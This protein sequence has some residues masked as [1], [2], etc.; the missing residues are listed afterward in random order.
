M[1]FLDHNIYT[2][3]WIAPLEIE[4]RA[5]LL[6][7]DERHWGQ[8]PIT[9][10]DEYY[11]YA[12]IMCGHHV[13]IATFPA[14]QEYGTGSAAALA[15]H[16]KTAFPNLWFGL[17]VGVAAGLPNLLSDPP[18]DIR[19]GDVLVA[20][21]L[22]DSAGLVAYDLG[23]VVGED[24]V[25]PLRF[26]QRFLPY[27][28]KMKGKLHINGNFLDPGQELDRY[29]DINGDGEEEEIVRPRR[30]D[31]ERT[32]VWYGPL[33]SGEKL[34]RNARQRNEL[35][36]RFNV[37]G[38]EMEAAGTM[39]RIPVGVIR[40]VCDYGDR[41][42]NKEWQ[43]YAAAM[44]AAYGKALTSGTGASSVGAG[45]SSG[46][47]I[48]ACERAHESRP[49]RRY[50]RRKRPPMKPEL[51]SP[52]TI[53]GHSETT[54]DS[55]IHHARR[56]WPKY[57]NERPALVPK[58]LV[59]PD[60]PGYLRPGS[61]TWEIETRKTPWT[62]VMYGL[63]GVG[64]S[65]LCL[66]AVVENENRF[67]GIFY[68]DASNNASALRDFLEIISR[69]CNNDS[70]W[71][72]MKADERIRL[73]R[74][75]LACQKK[76]W[77]LIVD[78]AG[79]EDV[80]LDMF[81]PTGGPGTI[82]ITTTDEQ[83]A[84]HSDAYCRIEAMNGEDAV[85]LLLKYRQPEIA[86][87][88]GQLEAAR[89][90]AADL[91]GGHHLAVT[92]AGSCIFSKHC[93][94]TEYCE[95]FQRSP[96][97]S[98]S[99]YKPRVGRRIGS[100]RQHVWKTFT[101]LLDQ[102]NSSN[103]TGSVQAIELLRTL[104]F[105]HHEGIQE[106]LFEEPWKDQ[107][108]VPKTSRFHF[109]L[110][111]L[112]WREFSLRNTFE[113]LY[114][115]SLVSYSESASHSRQYSMPRLVHTI[116]RES[117]SREEQDKYALRAVAMISSVLSQIPKSSLSTWIDNPAGFGLQRSLLPHIKA[118]MNGRLD[119]ICR[120]DDER[121]QETRT[122]MILILAK[123]CS[124]TGH[125]LDAHG[126]L[127][128]VCD[129]YKVHN[130][131]ETVYPLALIPMEQSATCEAQLGQ[132]TKAHD[133]R[134]RILEKREALRSD[135][136]TLCVAMMNL[137]DS[138]WMTGRR[139]EAL[140]TAR[141]ALEHRERVLK[142]GDPRLLR[143]KRKVAEYLHGSNQRRLALQLRE[144]ILEEIMAERSSSWTSKKVHVPEVETLNLLASASALAD[145][146]HWNGNLRSALSLRKQVYQ[147]RSRILG[148]DHPDT[149]LARD[150]LLSTQSS[151]CSSSFSKRLQ[152]QKQR[153][154]AV[155][156]WERVLGTDH[157]YTL[158]ARVNLGH[159]YR[160]I[161]QGKKALCEQQ[162]VLKVRERQFSSSET[163]AAKS[164]SNLLLPL[165]SSMQNVAS[166]HEKQGDFP[167]ALQMREEAL[168]IAARHHDVD[169]QAA[170]KLRNY[171]ADH[172]ARQEDDSS[173][174]TALEMRLLILE[175]QRE[176]HSSGKL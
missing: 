62:L 75:W 101:L 69:V 134:R 43:P 83:F 73:T 15:S 125:H 87:N 13:V 99:S 89:L 24:G 53:V 50:T 67:H 146:Y 103:E 174:R 102:I 127:D 12:G 92:Q 132:N 88:F 164:A 145:S 26:G 135:T 16:V 126:L 98:L 64:K 90:L 59:R 154:E 166:L 150:R 79:S 57:Q 78:N 105:F 153:L 51:T 5:A 155:K 110:G 18:R 39:N 47:E 82:I 159:S 156:T 45:Y 71:D 80:D 35:R 109:V 68:I 32:R 56:E 22:G 176:R 108:R 118:C 112:S 66:K 77:I 96:E 133:L 8:F 111:R 138:L 72:N 54:R 63:A 139:K 70:H 14:G 128:G 158:E 123:A 152:V 136:E 10:G 58:F 52:E 2:V 117:L 7:L 49:K 61:R 95:E 130:P 140:Q 34:M 55:S 170:F 100:Q 107:R 171:L 9:R 1:S 44:A 124:A 163:R 91:L 21:P 116:C 169:N 93:S 31:S 97:Q 120:G 161:G 11:F 17:L 167:A 28:E 42:K 148:H 23:K 137:A 173:H 46:S 157:P 65:Q 113:I 85:D 19:L 106:Q 60:V 172:H 3:A 48:S 25:R 4:L 94:Y 144:Q 162:A 147:V 74:A 168:A 149:L 84:T 40:G 37:I 160:A 114:R 81:I 142:P 122:E 121:D 38:L 151:Y 41:H 119:T 76:P 29:Y 6:M 36:D 143:T 30:P 33:G 86:L 20:L 115:Y 165:L 131:A 129:A 141:G 175:E 27:Y 104:C